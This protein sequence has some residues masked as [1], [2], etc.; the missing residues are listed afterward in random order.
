MSD[1]IIKTLLPLLICLCCIKLGHAMS[2]ETEEVLYIEGKKIDDKQ[3]VVLAK[4]LSPSLKFL[5]LPSNPITDE[6]GDFITKRF[7]SLTSLNL[8]GTNL[9]N[10]GVIALAQALT[11]LKDLDLSHVPFKKSG[12]K[13]IGQNLLPLERLTLAGCQL[14]PSACG[15]IASRGE[16]LR[17]LNIPFNY[18]DSQGTHNFVSA[19]HPFLYSL[20]VQYNKIKMV[21]VLILGRSTWFLNLR[22]LNISHNKVGS[23]GLDFI[24]SRL[25]H[26]RV[27]EISH[28]GVEDDQAVMIAETLHKLQQLNLESNRIGDKGIL[29]LVKVPFLKLRLM[30]LLF[31]PIGNEGLAALERFKEARKGKTFV[32][33]H[34]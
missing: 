3:L 16:N 32:C 22:E 27:L 14:Q 8:A 34:S 10:N 4:G 29:A 19:P 24:A 7:T 13:A 30:N 20:N 28:N 18:F 31:N 25:V 15:E 11:N 23:Y 26:L 33:W 1:R 6:G 2:L 17:V 21:D 12:A 9:T 5:C